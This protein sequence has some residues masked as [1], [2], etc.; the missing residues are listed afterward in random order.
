MA[1]TL[2]DNELKVLVDVTVSV[3]RYM[4]LHSRSEKLRDDAGDVSTRSSREYKRM[5]TNAQKTANP[6]HA[7]LFENFIAHPTSI[8]TTRCVERVVPV[9][10]RRLRVS[11][12]LEV[13]F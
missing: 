4:C 10:K 9:R 1:P 2:P 13:I 12:H 3:G 11:H 8:S 5:E 7:M 6:V